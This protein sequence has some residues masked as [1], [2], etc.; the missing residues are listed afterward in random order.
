MTEPEK[1][2]AGEHV[3][4]VGLPPGFLDKLPEENQRVGAA[5]LML[6]GMLLENR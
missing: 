5:V 3:L 1:P 2:Q 4:L 6:G